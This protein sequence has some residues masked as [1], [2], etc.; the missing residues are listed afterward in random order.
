MP[1]PEMPE[2]SLAGK[3]ALGGCVVWPEAPDRLRRNCHHDW[4]A[5]GIEPTTDA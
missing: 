2:E 5:D 1:D 4:R 3:V